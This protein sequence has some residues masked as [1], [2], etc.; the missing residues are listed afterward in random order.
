MAARHEDYGL[1]KKPTG[2]YRC[3]FIHK[4]V[5]V[6]RDTGCKSITDAKKWCRERI[7]EIDAN[8]AASQLTRAKRLNLLEAA[9]R[10][11]DEHLAKTPSY[12][13]AGK[14]E[15]RTI[16]DTIGRTVKLE[17]LSTADI[18]A[19]VAARER[20]GVKPGTIIKEVGRIEAMHNYAM[21]IWEYPVRAIAWSRVRPKDPIRLKPD[22]TTDMARAL[23]EHA[24]TAR[25]RNIIRMVLLTG[26]RRNEIVTL[27]WGTIYLD[28]R[29][30]RL[31]GKGNKEAELPLSLEATSL[32]SSIPRGKSSRVFDTTNL[33]RE[34]EATREAAGLTKF[35]FHD[36]R[37]AFATLL[38][39]AGAPIQDIQKQMRHSDVSTTSIYVHVGNHVLLPFL[40]QL[41]QTLSAPSSP[42]STSTPN[43]KSS[44]TGTGQ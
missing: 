25:I 41:G 33:R 43:E 8:L 28:R 30:F 44:G 35:R 36:L 19:F 29:K 31:I 38:S 5:R 4:S 42:K 27:E 11:T 17:D 7:A 40:E 18:K 34:W 12:E 15:I 10:Y 1:K 13:K 26:L 37:H 14:Y 24:T 39:E 2:T 22:I 23:I 32:L 9:T 16:L 3:D 6:A 20:G 21:E